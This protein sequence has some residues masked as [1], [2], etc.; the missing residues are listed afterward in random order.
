MYI[1]FRNIAYCCAVIT[2]LIS[3]LYNSL[4]LYHWAPNLWRSADFNH[5]YV[6][7]WLISRHIIPY[8]I[9]FKDTPWNAVF[10]WHELIPSATNPPL[11][12]ILTS[13]LAWLQPEQS[14][15]AW[16]A[17]L[18]L[19]A[20][21]SYFLVIN[22][23]AKSWSTRAKILGFLLYFG[24]WP[25]SDCFFYG[26]VQPILLLISVV[27]W[28]SARTGHGAL[29]AFFAGM[30]VSVKLLGWPIAIF[31]V[32]LF[33]AR[34]AV[35]FLI[36]IVVLGAVPM[37]IG[38]IEIYHS[39]F[40]K[41]LPIIRIWIGST[42]NVSFGGSLQ[43]AIAS[44]WDISD[45]HRLYLRWLFIDIGP[46]LF[47]FLAAVYLARFIH[48]QSIRELDGSMAVL[49]A[50]SFLSAPVAWHSYLIVL[51]LGLSVYWTYSERSMRSA[52]FILC[53][54]LIALTKPYSATDFNN[55]LVAAAVMLTTPL[56]VVCLTIQI[57]LIVRKRGREK[58]A[59]V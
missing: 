51:L 31:I 17:L 19:S 28:R 53:I 58:I 44:I 50:I 34:A 10:E 46:T 41:A 7:A 21:A 8:D 57:L 11:L 56:S 2:A 37:L 49:L 20:L 14:W 43:N 48:K 40:T 42:L 32:V 59:V 3:T 54:W 38:G 35:S 30:L 27:A 39:F 33:G 9:L 12:A 25:L 23:L 16:E 13:P 26:Q 55:K 24:S 22:D 52:S 18:F 1:R 5:Y 6:T 29:S 15:I 36:T 47:A 45:L 4:Y